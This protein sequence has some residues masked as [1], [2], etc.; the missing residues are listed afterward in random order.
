MKSNIEGA[1]GLPLEVFDAVRKSVEESRSQS[2]R[3]LAIL[4]SGFN[5]SDVK[6]SLGIV[7]TF[8]QQGVTS[9]IHGQYECVREFSEA[10]FTDDPER[11]DAQTL[12]LHGDDVQIAPIEDSGRLS[13]KIAKNTRPKSM[14]VGH[15]GLA[16]PMPPRSMR[17]DCV[18]AVGTSTS[19][20]CMKTAKAHCSHKSSCAAFG[21]FRPR[22]IQLARRLRIP[23]AGDFRDT[24]KTIR[25][26][27]KDMKHP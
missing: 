16:R 8:C 6:E 5:R 26:I 4:F 13:T 15:T 23:G 25:K 1:E 12:I 21:Q 20:R 9:G 17:T 10:D 24:A 18:P 7:A 27:S 2:Y 11:I 19:S 14:P 22:L 3:V